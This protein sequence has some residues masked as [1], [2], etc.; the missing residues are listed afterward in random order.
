MQQCG[1]FLHQWGGLSLTGDI[2]EHKMCFWWGEGRNGKSTLLETW[3]FVAGDY[4]ANTQIQTFLDAGKMQE[5]RSGDPTS[6][7]A[8]GGAH[9]ANIGAQKGARLDEALIKSTTGGDTV[10]ARHLNREFFSFVP[11]FKLTMFGNRQP[12]ITGADAGIWSRV[13]EVPWSVMIA[14]DRRDRRWR[15]N[16]AVR[17][18]EILE[19]AAGRSAGLDRSTASSSAV[20]AVEATEEYRADGRT[21]LAG[22]SANAWRMRLANRCALAR[23]TLCS[24]LGRKPMPRPCGRKKGGRSRLKIGG[25]NRSIPTVCAGSTFPPGSFRF[26]DFDVDEAGPTVPPHDGASYNEDDD[27]VMQMIG[28]EGLEVK[29]E[30]L[31]KDVRDRS[32]R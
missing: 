25:S 30:G 18:A 20:S 12:K 1:G 23:C 10:E 9:A 27:D 26:G 3:A 22:F 15:R 6:R 19:S 4:A 8:A 13:V 7:Q 28:L 29:L 16:C 24:W 2:G 32:C 21:R 11:Q 17:A 5:R 31:W 14:P